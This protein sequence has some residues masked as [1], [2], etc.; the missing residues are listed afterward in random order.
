MIPWRK[1]KPPRFLVVQLDKIKEAPDVQTP[2]RPTFL[3]P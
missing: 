1:I 2:T 3:T